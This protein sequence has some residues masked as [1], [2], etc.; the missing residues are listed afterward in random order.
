MFHH[1]ERFLGELT[2]EVSSFPPS[3]TLHALLYRLCEAHASRL[4]DCLKERPWQD[5]AAKVDHRIRR[6]QV[7]YPRSWQVEVRRHLASLVKDEQERLLV[8]C[9]AVLRAL[10]GHHRLLRTQ[11]ERQILE[12]PARFGG[13]RMAF[14]P[15]PENVIA[16]AVPQSQRLVRDRSHLKHEVREILDLWWHLVNLDRSVETPCFLELEARVSDRLRARWE[17]SGDLAIG[18]AVPF[19]DLDFEFHSDPDRCHDRRGIPY[20][21]V[22]L[23][24]EHLPRA[25]SIVDHILEDCAERRVDVLCFPEL[26]LDNDLLGHL[27]RRLKTGDPARQPALVVAGSFH[28]SN[29]LDWVN[30]CHVL[31][32]L[33]RLLFIQDKCK[34][35]EIPSKLARDMGPELCRKLGIDERGGFE[36]IRCSTEVVIADCFLGRLATPICLDFCGKELRELFIESRTNLLFVPS[37]TPRMRPFEEACRDLG[38]DC[39]GSCFVVNSAWLLQQLRALKEEDVFLGYVPA[40]GALS[41]PAKVSEA[42]AVFS[43]R[44]LLAGPWRRDVLH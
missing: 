40:K 6:S 35:F 21:V 43:V 30:R 42:L 20:R 26:T 4:D 34:A 39:R 14:L 36:D 32:G 22:G 23:K 15:P 9:A 44:V 41:R 38:T 18:L 31:D 37:M 27:Q 13:G 12:L 17:E 16:D 24:P 11:M 2:D 28:L 25:R 33:G 8:G 29:E 1:P 7:S 5:F 19:V 3:F 10:D